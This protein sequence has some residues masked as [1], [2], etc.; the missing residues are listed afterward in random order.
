MS[1]PFWKSPL[2]LILTASL[3]LNLFLASVFV[4]K[5][6]RGEPPR[7]SAA[8]EVLK[9]ASPD[10]R[11]AV[12]EIRDLRRQAFRDKQQEMQQARQ[13]I[14]EAVKAEPFDE[15]ELRAAQAAL[16]AEFIRVRRF[17]ADSSVEL[18]GRLG[19]EDR[20]KLAEF[21]Q[22]REEDRKRRRERRR[23]SREF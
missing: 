6:F 16:M 13:R 2:K 19:P 7:Q 17:V 14:Y 22:A 5:L 10:L 12:R 3:V 1:A 9:D 11:E 23:K 8:R 18:A 15:E 20:Q 21:L 4:G